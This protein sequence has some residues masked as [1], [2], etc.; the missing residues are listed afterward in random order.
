MESSEKDVIFFHSSVQGTSGKPQLIRCLTYIVVMVL[1]AKDHREKNG[2][3]INFGE[4]FKTV[5]FTGVVGSVISILF[6]LIWMNLIDTSVPEKMAEMAMNSTR[7]MLEKLGADENT[8]AD[9]IEKAEEEMEGKFTPFNFL[10][11]GLQ[12]ILFGIIPSAII[13]VI[14]KKEEPVV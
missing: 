5:F 8:I 6:T 3:F 10:L 7:D 9:S 1:A 12:N 14:M 11:Q 13:A 2:G 4:A